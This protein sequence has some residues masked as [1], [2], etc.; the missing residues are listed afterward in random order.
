VVQFVVV[1]QLFS[2]YSYILCRN[3]CDVVCC[4]VVQRVAAD[5]VRRYVVQR[6]AAWCSVV[7]RGAAW[8][9][10]VQRGAVWCSVVQCGSAWCSVV[11]CGAACCSVLQSFVV[12]Q[13]LQSCAYILCRNLRDA[14]CCRVE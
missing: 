13:L 14:V 12:S 9:S 3:L 5:C 1:C 8:C 7:Q 11:Q 4:T 10:V 6:A 2:L